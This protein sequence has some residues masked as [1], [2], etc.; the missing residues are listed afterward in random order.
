MLEASEALSL[1]PWR[2][3]YSTRDRGCNMKPFTRIAL[4]FGRC[5]LALQPRSPFHRSW[6]SSLEVQSANKVT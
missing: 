1:D 3:A 6:R 2:K 5:K 4:C